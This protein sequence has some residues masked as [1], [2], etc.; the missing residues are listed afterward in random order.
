MLHVCVIVLSV[1]HEDTC[2]PHTVVHT[3]NTTECISDA[4]ISL[5]ICKGQCASHSI[6]TSTNGLNLMLEDDCECC[7]PAAIETKTQTINCNGEEEGIGITYQTATECQC[8][9]CPAESAA[10]T[11]AAS[12]TAASTTAAS[13]TAAQSFK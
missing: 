4:V 3:F 8:S 7:K 12:T 1:P 11:T 2:Q 10:S 9:S 13:T 5:Q 6:V